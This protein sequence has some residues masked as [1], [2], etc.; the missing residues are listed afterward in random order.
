MTHISDVDRDVPLITLKALSKSFGGH[1]ALKNITLTLNKGEVHCLAGANGCGKSTLIKTISGVY[2]PDDGSEIIIDE[3]S[4][5]RLTPDRARALGVQV[6]Y[7]DLSLFPNLTV[8]ENIA[9]EYNLKGYFGWFNKQKIKQKACQILHELAFS[10]DPDA[11]VQH[12]PIAQRQQVA[13]CRALVAD[14]RL[15]I[16]DEPTASLTRTEVNQLLRTVNYLRDKHITV[17]FVSH[18]LDEVKEISDRITVIRDGEKVGTWPATELSTGR[19]TEL[20]TG[21]TITHEQK[22]PNA[23]LGKVVLQLENLSRKG[24]FDDISFSLHRGEVL[25]LCGLLGSGRTELALSL[26]GIT[27]PDSGKIAIDG[28]PVRIKDNTRAIELGIGYVSEDRLTLGAVLQQSIADNMVLSILQHIRTPLYLVDEAKQ[29]ALV[30]EWVKDLDIKITDAD[31]ALSTL[32]GGNQQKVVLAKWILT[33][34][35]VLILDSP[36]VGVDI[37][38]KDSIYKLIHR[39]SGV[40]ISVLLLSDEIPEAYYNCDRILHMQQGRI[41]NELIPNQMTEQQLAE[42]ING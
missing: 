27:H 19:I 16:M 17:V 10:L 37:G 29:N 42:V 31:N 8:A 28:N 13:I 3:K 30:Q 11:L 18:R 21:L 9:F 26:F 7:Q 1:Q 32:S 2:A 34:P 24:Q 41:V 25:G 12:L 6:I 20:M 22:L 4:Y 33:K 40:G 35:K 39:L 23:E 15:V 5:R 36:T 14:A 38:A